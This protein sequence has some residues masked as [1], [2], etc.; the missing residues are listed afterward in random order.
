[1]PKFK[2]Y[3]G[4]RPHALLRYGNNCMVV[5]FAWNIREILKMQN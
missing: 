1:M 4:E 5:G 2:K 3:Y